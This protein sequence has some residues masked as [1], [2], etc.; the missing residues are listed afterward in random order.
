[1]CEKYDS[2]YVR[3]LQDWIARLQTENEELRAKIKWLE[4]SVD[5][6]QMEVTSLKRHIEVD[7]TGIFEGT[8]EKLE[9]G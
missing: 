8:N 7:F 4:V 6:Y 1:M 9:R 2:L 3:F 5:A